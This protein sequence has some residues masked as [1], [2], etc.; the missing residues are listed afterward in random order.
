VTD[1]SRAL[2]DPLPPQGHLQGVERE[3]NRSPWSAQSC[4][5]ARP[6]G[7]LSRRP[8]AVVPV[9]P[10][11]SPADAD[12]LAELDTR[13]AAARLEGDYFWPGVERRLAQIP[14]V[15][16][17]RDP[18]R[19]AGM[20]DAERR[21]AALLTTRTTGAFGRNIG[22]VLT[23]EDAGR[24]WPLFAE[25]PDLVDEYLD[26]IDT[27]RHPDDEAVDTTHMMLKI[28]ECSPAVPKTPAPH[29]T[30]IA[31]GAARHRLAARRLL[32]DHP[33]VRAAA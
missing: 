14:D 5:A 4:C 23:L 17:L 21:V 13:P 30:S 22:A 27:K 1:Q 7:R 28:I 24:W 19:Q 15:R 18:L 25:R 2:L 12:L 32:G 31:L 10:T 11:A 16:V 6:T 3:I 29:L 8:G 9:L 26:G 20:T 33:G